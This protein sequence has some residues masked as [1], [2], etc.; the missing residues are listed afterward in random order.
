MFKN[1][2]GAKYHLPFSIF[3][4]GFPDSWSRSSEALAAAKSEAVMAAG[5]AEAAGAP[6]PLVGAATPEKKKYNYPFDQLNTQV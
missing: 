3:A 4:K 1:S 6:E 5:A 2:H